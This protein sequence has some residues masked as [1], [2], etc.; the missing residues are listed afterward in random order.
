LI[1][2]S[3]WTAKQAV[4]AGSHL[5]LSAVKSKARPQLAV[6]TDKIWEG[7]PFVSAKLR[8]ALPAVAVAAAAAETGVA[9]VE[10]DV[11]A[12]ETDVAAVETDAAVAVAAVAGAAASKMALETDFSRS[13]QIAS[14]LKDSLSNA[15]WRC[16]LVS[17]RR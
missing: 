16:K 11:A 8:N 9:A 17:C 10:T 14:S 15:I 6:L 3:L 1:S 2:I 13:P 7:E 5:L 12:V 4:L